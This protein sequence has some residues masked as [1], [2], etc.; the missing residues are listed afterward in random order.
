MT[1]RN[2]SVN[3]LIYQNLHFPAAHLA[4]LTHLFALFTCQF[5]TAVAALLVDVHA[6]LPA[7]LP[8]FQ[9]PMFNLLYQFYLLT[10][11]IISW[12]F[13]RSSNLS[14]LAESLSATAAILMALLFK[15]S[16]RASS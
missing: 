9:I 11:S 13:A 16:I 10:I 5:A 12:L 3:L 15:L 14:I 2:W 4:P 1:I 8:L 7:S 6:L